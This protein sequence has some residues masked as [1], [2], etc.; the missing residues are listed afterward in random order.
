[1]CTW[2]SSSRTTTVAALVEHI[3]TES[4]KWLK[5][6]SPALAGFAWQRGYGVFS[7]S[8][9][10]LDRLVA[11]IDGQ[12]AHHAGRDWPS[13]YRALLDRHGVAYDER[14]VWD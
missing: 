5:R 1:M 7:V 8:P 9:D 6:Q 13:E 11:Y 4:S 10:G 2:R 14:Y 3:K 12:E